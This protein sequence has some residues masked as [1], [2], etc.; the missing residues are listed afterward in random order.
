MTDLTSL[1]ALLQFA[2]GLFPSG[3]FAHS[4]GLETYA[5][6]G[7][8]RDAAGLSEF[9]S[10]HL[11]GSAGP[12]DAVAAA[13]A[14]RAGQARD[15][16]ACI[17][18]DRGLDAMKTVPEFRAASR[19][20]GRQTARAAAA[21]ALG[22]ARA[23]AGDASATAG[24]AGPGAGQREAT[25]DGEAFA[26]RL[27]AAIDDELT[28]GHHAVVFGAVTGRHGASPEV[29][30]AA[31]LQS[32]AAL[33]VGAGLRLLPIGQL[34]G[35]RVLASMRESI[36]RLARRAAAAGA[37]D[38]W[39]FTPGLEIAGVRHADLEGRLFRS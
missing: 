17:E 27:A 25:L 23:T 6:E 7:K 39:S 34:D 14:A 32:T 26:E 18:L 12:A 36:A 29:A 30:A 22:R 16:D 10:T 8:I 15:L 2:D 13:L 28:P 1:I 3:G 21:T 33:L 24:G 20:M 31:F 37:D 19:Q 11:E 9:V 5:Q 4:F 35:Q 38:M